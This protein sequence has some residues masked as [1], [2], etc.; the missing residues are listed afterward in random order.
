MTSLSMPSLAAPVDVNSADVQSLSDA[1]TG[2]GPA[3]AKAIV[4]YREQNGPFSSVEDLLNVKG[5]GPTVLE[6]NKAD[7]IIG[8]E[9][10]KSVAQ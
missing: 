9:A 10:S 4:E 6:R 8:G 1:L 5:V 7:I 3:I 2:I